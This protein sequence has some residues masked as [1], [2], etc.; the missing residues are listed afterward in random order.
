[1][2]ALNCV[3]SAWLVREIYGC[4]FLVA[5][6]RITLQ[7]LLWFVTFPNHWSTGIKTKPNLM[8]SYIFW[9]FVLLDALALFTFLGQ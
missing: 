9:N 6:D 5:V 2:A 8:I 7:I 4:R 3:Y 1:M